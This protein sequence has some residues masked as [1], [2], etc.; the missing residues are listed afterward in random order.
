MKKLSII[1]LSIIILF[2]TTITGMSA[3]YGGNDRQVQKISKPYLDKLFRAINTD[4]INLFKENLA[5]DFKN[6]ITKKTFDDIKAY[7]IRY[8]GM[9]DNVTY[10]G[11]LDRHGYTTSLW[12]GKWS[13]GQEVLVILEIS[14]E[15]DGRY[16]I[17]G[18]QFK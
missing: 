16:L 4:N 17:R 14:K 5:P 11:K 7:L 9:P 2:S 18:F 10:M 6:M 13:K 8:Y 15:P 1:S 3:S 12:K